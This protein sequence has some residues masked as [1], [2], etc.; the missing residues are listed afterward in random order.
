MDL[1]HMKHRNMLTVGVNEARQHAARLEAKAA[2]ER[3]Q[4]TRDQRLFGTK[5]RKQLREEAEQA[6]RARARPEL[7][8]PK[9]VHIQTVVCGGGAGRTDGRN[10][11]LCT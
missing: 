5:S 9:C 6:L 4:R 1:L 3:L 10:G 2:K 7:P 8:H 11:T